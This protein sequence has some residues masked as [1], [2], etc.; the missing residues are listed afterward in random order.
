MSRRRISTSPGRQRV[1]DDGMDI[2]S[3][4]I[5]LVSFVAL[6]GAIEGLSRV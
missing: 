2:V 4:A 5:A 3:I 6:L 1:Q